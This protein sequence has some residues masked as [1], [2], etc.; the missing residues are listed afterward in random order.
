[1][2]NTHA[3]SVTHAKFET[4]YHPFVCHFMKCVSRL[5]ISGLLNVAN[6]RP[7]A[8]DREFFAHQYKPTNHVTHPFPMEIVDF[9]HGPYAIYNQELF[10]HI[11]DL[12]FRTPAPEPA[13]L[14]RDS[15]VEVHFRSDRCR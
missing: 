1:M 15:M 6:Q 8:A 2:H 5:G 12:I 14:R 7:K 4:F 11:P 3:P 9:D 10:F 13:I